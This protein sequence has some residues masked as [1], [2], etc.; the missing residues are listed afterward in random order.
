[1]NQTPDLKSA[2][3]QSNNSL[4]QLLRIELLAPCS[5]L[6]SFILFSF[7]FFSRYNIIYCTCVY[8]IQYLQQYIRYISYSWDGKRVLIL[9][10]RF[11][12][13]WRLSSSS[14]CS[15]FALLLLEAQYFFSLNGRLGKYRYKGQP[16]HTRPVHLGS[17][18]EEKY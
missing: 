18:R 10:A 17:I 16:T 11:Y 7:F 9:P 1:M 8:N 6:A 15:P 14:V 12:Y 13:V 5:F 3:L 4:T 2:A